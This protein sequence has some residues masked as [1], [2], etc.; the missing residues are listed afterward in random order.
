M[1]AISGRNASCRATSLPIPALAPVINTD[2]PGGVLIVIPSFLF[3]SSRGWLN[4]AVGPRG[5]Y[6]GQAQL[7]LGRPSAAASSFPDGRS[8]EV[9]SRLEYIIHSATHHMAWRVHFH[10]Y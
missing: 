8:S 10:R 4:L 7:G 1:R 2:F 3:S 5:G 6:G 9:V